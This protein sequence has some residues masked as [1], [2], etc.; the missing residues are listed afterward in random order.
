MKEVNVLYDRVGELYAKGDMAEEVLELPRNATAT[1]KA[2]TLFG[3]KKE[4]DY[5][6]GG[7]KVRKYVQTGLLIVK[8]VDMQENAL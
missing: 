7:S 8:I 3:I 4:V 6:C 5:S 2:H 1:V